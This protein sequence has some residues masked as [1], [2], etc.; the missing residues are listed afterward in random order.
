MAKKAAAPATKITPKQKQEIVKAVAA[1]VQAGLIK[2]RLISPEEREKAPNIFV[3]RRLTSVFLASV[4]RMA[5]L[6][7]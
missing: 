7:D 3:G 4:T 6:Q 5:I 1:L 2:F